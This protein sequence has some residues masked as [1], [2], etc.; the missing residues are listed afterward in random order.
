M[1]YLLEE[2]VDKLGFEGGQPQW[3][4]DD[5]RRVALFCLLGNRH[6]NSRDTLMECVEIINAIPQE[7]IRNITFAEMEKLGIPVTQ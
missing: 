4:S 1:A 3:K 2:M 7:N 5:H 6:V